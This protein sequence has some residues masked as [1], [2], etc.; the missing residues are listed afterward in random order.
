LVDCSGEY[1]RDLNATPV[2]LSIPSKIFDD[3]PDPA[4][5][6]TRYSELSLVGESFACLGPKNTISLLFGGA[7]AVSYATTLSTYRL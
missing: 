3:P 5:G 2:F 6:F 4:S 7:A 1:R